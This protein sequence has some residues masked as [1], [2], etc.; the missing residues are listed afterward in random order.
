MR[1]SIT[2]ESGFTLVEIMLAL[3]IAAMVFTAIFGLVQV[4]VNVQVDVREITDSEQVGPA[5][6]SQ[7]S[8]DLR[9]AYYYNIADNNFMHG[10]PVEADG[11][12]RMDQ[13]HFL[14]TRTSLLA[15]TR[16]ISEDGR[17]YK[18]GRAHV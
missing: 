3:V 9:N 4:G 12:S 1:Q 7:L 11:E 2:R 17:D 8:E 15:D 5:I 13:I 18:I 6:L 10:R 16:I 14:T